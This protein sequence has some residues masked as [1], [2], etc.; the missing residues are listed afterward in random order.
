MTSFKKNSFRKI[1][2]VLTLGVNIL[3]GACQEK[4]TASVGLHGVDYSG[5]EFSYYVVEPNDP[6][7]VT[8]GEHIDPFSAGGITC[9]A[10]LPIQW[11]PGT[12][13][14]IRTTHWLPKR[15]PQ[16]PLPEITEI[17]MVDVPR[18]TS[19]KPEE[20]WVLREPGGRIS[21][22]LSDL[23]PDHPKWPGRVKG[24]P[25][26]SLEYRRERWEIYR[27]HE[28]GNV[29]LY[30]DLLLELKE[31]PLRRAEESWGYTKSYD[32]KSLAKYTGPDDPQ[33][34]DELAREYS[35]GLNRSKDRLQKIM[36]AKP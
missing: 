20:L 11:K 19:G 22:V 2:I 24:W 35:E 21:V 18:Y 7:K 28:Q 17:H 10:E 15:K 25:M 8:G 13:L 30:E 6:D 29:K 16:D 23:Q 9:C 3:L 4:S 31:K 27:K 34:I 36:D 33:Y 14:T 26:P 5:S 12:Q 1:A 32:S